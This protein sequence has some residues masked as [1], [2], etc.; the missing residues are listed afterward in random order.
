M[1]A[2]CNIIESVRAAT[3]RA[4]EAA[5]LRAT[6]TGMPMAG[7]LSGRLY[8]LGNCAIAADEDELSLGG[9]SWLA[10]VAAPLAVVG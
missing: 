1:L 9:C 7:G 10:L 4:G 5:D 2:V 8:A 6:R 3:G